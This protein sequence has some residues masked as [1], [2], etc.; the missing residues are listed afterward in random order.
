ML[1]RTSIVLVVAAGFA[2]LLGLIHPGKRPIHLVP[3]VHAQDENSGCS[4]ASVKGSYA[5]DRRGTL[6]ASILGLSAP[7]PWGE[8][9][10]EQFDGAGALSGKATVN[11]GGAVVSGTLTGTYTVNSDCTGTKTINT[12]V[13]VTVHE[14]IVVTG[15][16]QRMVGTQTDPWAVV[17][18]KAEKIG[19]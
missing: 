14:A 17:Q 5:L 1:R 11:V 15:G 3:V 6:V 2:G 8:V 9:A 19:E 13:G 7:A 16:G 12:S 18:T 4:L 10:F